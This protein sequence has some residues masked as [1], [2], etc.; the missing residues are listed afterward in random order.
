MDD[1]QILLRPR[2]APAVLVEFVELC[3]DL[4]QFIIAKLIVLAKRYTR[5]FA[6][7]IYTQ[8]IDRIV[9]IVAAVSVLVVL[10]FNM[11]RG[12]GGTVVPGA[13]ICPP[14]QIWDPSHGHCH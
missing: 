10:L 5:V 8:A 7:P 11:A 6:C 3:D 12:N 4:T 2:A 14:G 1:L 13:G 9:A